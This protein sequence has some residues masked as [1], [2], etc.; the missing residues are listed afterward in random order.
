M[1]EVVG[2]AVVVVKQDDS[3]IDLSKSGESAGKGFAGGFSGIFKK[4]PQLAAVAAVGAI[5]SKQFINALNVD[6]GAHKIAAQLGLTQTESAQAG[7]VAGE[8]YADNFGENI[9]EVQESVGDVIA[10]IKGMRNANETD[11]KAATQAALEYT[12][13]F[14]EDLPES[15]NHANILINSGLAKDTVGAFDLMTKAAQQLPESLRGDFGDA[16]DEY[17][18]HFDMLGLSGKAA[19]SVLLA[20]ADQG[21]IGIDKAGDAVK[22]FGIRATDLSDTNAQ[23]AF[24]QLGLNAQQM[25]DDILAGGSKARKATAE[26]AKA[27]LAIKDPAKQALV[28]TQLFGTQLED[29]GKDNVK[30]FLGGLTGAEGGLGKVKDATQKASDTMNDTP[31]VQ[32]QAAY[33]RAQATVTNFAIAA[34]GP[35]ISGLRATG[36]FVG[37]A[38]TQVS[39]FLAPAF[40]T[41]GTVITTQVVPAI[42][43]VWGFIQTN[44]VPIFRL[45][46]QV[47]VTELLPA[48]LQVAGFIGTTLIPTIAGIVSAIAEKLTPIIQA[49]ADVFQTRILPAVQAL[50]VKFQTQLLP[51]LQPIIARIVELAKFLVQVGAVVIKVVGFFAKL[52]YTILSVVLPPLIRIIGYILSKVL[53]I[54]GDLIVVFAKVVLALLNVGHGIGSF[55][56]DI[57]RLAGKIA[58]FV[59]GTL[60]DLISAVASVPGRLI[61]LGKQFLSAGSSLISK[62]LHG[63]GEAAKGVGGIVSGIASAVFDAV[64]NSVNSVV[65]LLNNAIPNKLGVGPLAINI[66][67]NPIPHLQ[68]GTSNFAGG[69]VMVGE[70]GP[71]KVFL[72]AGSRV[73]TAAQTRQS[74][75]TSFDIAALTQALVAALAAHG[76]RLRP[77]QFMLPSG[78]PEAAAMATLNRLATIS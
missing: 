15:I 39:S 16:V 73:L 33:R 70:A 72:P 13:V 64:K 8:L 57:G 4:L 20:G 59:T 10:G 75:S 50:V 7:K 55:I 69:T 76:D 41:I 27:I 61:D 56:G 14:D 68:T 24:Q 19:F 29:I 28:A 31:L 49:L 40:K 17:S 36:E 9:G 78:D 53:P 52:G 12:G 25:A 67:D 43:S 3:G 44:L 11:L 22:E 45:I 58:G 60:G 54:I 6:A 35:V 63:M 62:L 2:E 34:L 74:D 42:T 71:E 48:F 30:S 26:T 21:S 5:V 65:D 1:S 18:K 47:V 46:I 38:S 32:L 37:T 77:I 51:I 23:A 66:P